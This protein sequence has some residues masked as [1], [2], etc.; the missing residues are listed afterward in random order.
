M[1]TR[2]VAAHSLAPAQLDQ[3]KAFVAWTQS[4]SSFNIP[5]YTHKKSYDNFKKR[6]PSHLLKAQVVWIALI[7]LIIII[8]I[9]ICRLDSIP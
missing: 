6:N 2:F 7:C 5:K 1:S 9:S 3:Q 4:K 8:V